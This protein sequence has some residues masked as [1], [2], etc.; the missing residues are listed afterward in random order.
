MAGTAVAA[1]VDD[2]GTAEDVEVAGG[3]GP[4]V[5]EAAGEVARGELGAEVAKQQDELPSCGMGE[6]VKDGVELVGVGRGALSLRRT[7]NY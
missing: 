7:A 4:A 5:G 2:A 3:R 6:C 1:D